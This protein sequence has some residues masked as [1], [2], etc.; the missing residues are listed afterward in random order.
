MEFFIRVSNGGHDAPINSLP[1]PSQGVILGGDNKVEMLWAGNPA[2]KTGVVLG[3]HLWSLDKNMDSQ[4]GRGDLEKGLQTLAPG[5]HSLS[6]V[7]PKVWNKAEDEEKN[8]A[9]GDFNPTRRQM[10]LDVP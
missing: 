9:T 8:T 1:Y 3:D 5:Q 4:Q 10:E 2:D 6:V 7:N